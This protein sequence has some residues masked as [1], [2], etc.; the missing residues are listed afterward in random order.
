MPTTQT[1]DDLLHWTASGGLWELVS[2]HEGRVV[3]D[4][5]TCTG[6]EVVGRID[7]DDPALLAFVRSDR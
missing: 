5:V 7:S 2:M 6:V 3:L 1:L 4:L